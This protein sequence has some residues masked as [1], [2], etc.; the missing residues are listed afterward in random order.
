MIH[1]VMFCLFVFI[2]VYSPFNTLYVMS[3]AVF[4]LS[5]TV[6]SLSG[7]TFEVCCT[8]LKS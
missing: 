1:S 8:V 4:S 3:G 5:Q 7:Y 2:V 6:L